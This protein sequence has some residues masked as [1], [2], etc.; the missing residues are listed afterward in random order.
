MHTDQIRLS[1]TLKVTQI[2]YRNVNNLSAYERIQEVRFAWERDTNNFRGKRL[3]KKV[4]L[5]L[6][7]ILANSD[8]LN[9]VN[10]AKFHQ[11]SS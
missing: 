7:I 2:D 5:P 10:F 11:I 3:K 1:V 4:H 9:E 6:V 8:K